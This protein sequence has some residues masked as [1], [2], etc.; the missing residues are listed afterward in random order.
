MQKSK[1]LTFLVIL[2]LIVSELAVFEFVPTVKAQ[3]S[4]FLLTVEVVGRNVVFKGENVSIRNVSN[5]SEVL[6]QIYASDDSL[7]YNG[8]VTANSTLV[9]SPPE[10]YGLFTVKAFVANA[11]AE[12]WFWLQNL[13]GMS[14]APSTSLW[15]WKGV[16][17]NL[18]TVVE[19]GKISTY[20][21]T[22]SFENA[23]LSLDW[24]SEVFTKLK[25]TTV[26]MESN[27]ECWHIKTYS[28]K[29]KVDSWIMNTWFG[30]KI[31]VNGT[32]QA[33]KTF[34]WNFKNVYG[35]ILWMLD[36]ARI[37]AGSANL[38]YD[39]SDMAKSSVGCSYTVD[40]T[41]MKLDVTL[42]SNFD[43]DPTIFSDGFEG[44]DFGI[45][46]NT[47]YAW[48]GTSYG[49]GGTISV[50]TSPVHH[51]TYAE[52]ADQGGSGAWAVAYKNFATTYSIIYAR[53]YVRLS[54]L[55]SSGVRLYI[56]PCIFEGSAAA[57]ILVGACVYNDA[58]TLKWDLQY[59]TDSV[60]ENHAYSTTP[61][62][63]ANQWYC[64]EV[65]FV[66]GSGN[67]EVG[68]YIDG[69]LVISV[70]GL[71]NNAYSAGRLE[72]GVYSTSATYITVYHDCVVVADTYIGPEGDT[73]P[74]TYSNVGTNTTQA[75]QPCQFSV[76][77]ND[78]VNVSGFIFGTNNT[79]AWVNDTWT[80][81][82][83]FYN[84]TAAWSNVTKT[85]NDTIHIV[86]CW[87]I[88]A[89]DTS[90]NW[91]TTGTQ[92]LTTT[93]A[94]YSS[95]S[96]PLSISPIPSRQ[97]TYN[98]AAFQAL[99][100]LLEVSR[101]F[102]ASRIAG[103]LV[104][105]IASTTRQTSYT[106][107]TSQPLTF[108]TETTL[109]K[110]IARYTSQMLTILTEASR[111]QS[112]SRVTGQPLQLLVSTSRQT[113]YNRLTTQ[114]LTLLQTAIRQLTQLRTANQPVAI[115][116][117][118][119]RLTSYQRASSTP[120]TI[121]ADALRVTSASRTANQQLTILLST[122]R[123]STYSRTATS[124]IILLLSTVIQKTSFGIQRTVDLTITVNAVAQRTHANMTRTA[125]ALVQAIFSV[126]RWVFPVWVPS[127]IASGPITTPHFEITVVTFSSNLNILQ[128]NVET[129]A[130]I[131]FQ[132][133]NSFD[134]NVTIQYWITN[135]AET[136]TYTAKNLT[137]PLHASDH[138][139][140]FYALT[141]NTPIFWTA[142]TND[143][144]IW[145][146]NAEYN[147]QTTSESRV[148]FTPIPW[149][150]MAKPFTPYFLLCLALVAIYIVFFKSD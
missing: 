36:G 110:I 56:Y 5:A 13:Q 7:V 94:F 92:T 61:T 106:R 95:A 117:Q 43:V 109:Q 21:L 125:D 130:L 3:E 51:G 12:T 140:T 31:R 116:T 10:I 57:H 40:K 131:K 47:G 41:G 119:A 124:N 15:V 127:Y 4:G 50:V 90:N 126:N 38:V 129:K 136:E 100:I 60:E 24:L 84:S 96:Q 134:G 78:N 71:T 34:K 93:S 17:C 83:V 29:N 49:N 16:N 20:L 26:L 143:R 81:F 146:M 45:D 105:F 87:Q 8:S 121:I 28:D 53:S 86:V 85:L 1:L 58:G 141:L 2:V 68:L 59:R 108:I 37:P 142:V 114:T 120:L 102:S 72:L 98:R 149:L 64:V 144:L 99:Q 76:L 91:N 30:V 89:N 19:A 42:Q 63:N 111:S 69:N 137:V 112:L 74:P 122:S 52:S 104:N 35:N 65:K 133:L 54:S 150:T 145:H 27:G 138:D 32:L 75:G 39:W 115:L 18:S 118:A 22:V 73:T 11:S 132:P 48:T 80:S 55:P 9:F 82:T 88:W 147:N 44:G 135:T 101:Y 77:W 14:V 148:L 23:S 70:T 103:Q 25:P 107:A 79:G 33:A 67:G 139:P 62:I 128:N 113:S 6:L 66:Q 123:Y 97:S 46:P